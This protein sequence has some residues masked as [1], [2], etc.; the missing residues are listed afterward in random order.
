M[1]EFWSCLCNRY[2]DAVFDE[3]YI[4]QDKQFHANFIPF[5]SAIVSAVCMPPLIPEGSEGSESRLKMVKKPME[6]PSVSETN[7]STIR[8]VL[9]P[10]IHISW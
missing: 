3:L 6:N 9:P 5:W 2:C 8:N 7:S 4:V 10:L 1:N